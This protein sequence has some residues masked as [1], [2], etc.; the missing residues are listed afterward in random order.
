MELSKRYTDEFLKGIDCKQYGVQLDRIV[1][2]C[3]EKHTD[4]HDDPDYQRVS[5]EAEDFFHAQQMKKIKWYN[6]TMGKYYPGRP[7]CQKC[8][9]KGTVAFLRGLEFVLAPCS[10]AAGRDEDD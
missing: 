10:C 1:R 8:L 9:N 5:R 7:I 6:S 4:Y 3:G 2:R